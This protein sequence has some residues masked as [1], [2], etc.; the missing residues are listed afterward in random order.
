MFPFYGQISE[1]M[2]LYLQ[3][4]LYIYLYKRGLYSQLQIKK[5][6]DY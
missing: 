2:F 3:Q 4:L 5:V 6:I 1:K